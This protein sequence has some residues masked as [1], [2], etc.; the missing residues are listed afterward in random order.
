MSSDINEIDWSICTPERAER[1]QLRR[2]AA[3]PLRRKLRALEQ[4][5][6]HAR[7]TIASRKARGLAWF[8]PETGELVQDTPRDAAPLP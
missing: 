6:D 2:W 5:C 8:D 1:E 4:M 7:E 3:L